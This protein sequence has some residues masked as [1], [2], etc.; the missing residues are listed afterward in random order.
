MLLFDPSGNYPGGFGASWWDESPGV[1]E[2]GREGAEVFLLGKGGI[3]AGS[4]D[5][6]CVFS[7][8]PAV[9]H[10]PG[11]EVIPDSSSQI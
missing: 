4:V 9:H 6:N 11:F 2:L 3:S 10:I 7:L 1:L 8:Q 5:G